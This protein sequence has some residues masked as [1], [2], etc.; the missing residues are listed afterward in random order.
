MSTSS[1]VPNHT[2][3]EGSVIQREHRGASGWTACP[4]ERARCASRLPPLLVLP[5]VAMAAIVAAAVVRPRRVVVAG[6][7][8]EPTLSAGDR[9]LVGRTRPVRVGDVVALADP[10]NPGRLIVKRVTAVR[11]GEVVIRGDNSDA[12]IDSRTFGPV[13]VQAVL[14]KVIRRY[15]P[16]H[17]ASRV[18]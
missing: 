12:S 9:L 13:P 6:R 17:R 5:L 2:Q 11:L 15:G 4:I 14:G 18:Q 3:G 10:T 8:M 1:Q 16:P 7:S